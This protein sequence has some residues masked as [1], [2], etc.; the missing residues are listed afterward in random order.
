MFVHLGWIP[1]EAPSFPESGNPVV[2]S[3]FLKVAKRIPDF[4]E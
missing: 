2:D 3:A 1:F 4:R